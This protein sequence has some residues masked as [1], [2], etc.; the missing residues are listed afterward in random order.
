MAH[1]SS[2]FKSGEQRS[3]QALFCFCS[4]VPEPVQT[5]TGKGACRS[6]GQFAFKCTGCQ[7]APLPAE[8]HTARRTHFLPAAS[9][10]IRNR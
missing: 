4:G 3:M 8:S 9:N 6:P 7:N 1:R 5:D 10:G 2:L